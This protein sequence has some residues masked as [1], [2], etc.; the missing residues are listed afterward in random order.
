MP[1]AEER[2]QWLSKL[3]PFVDQLVENKQSDADSFIYQAYLASLERDRD[4]MI[5]AL[6]KAFELGFRGRWWLEI[7]PI[8]QH[9]KNDPQFMELMLEWKQE[10]TRMR[11]L[12]EAGS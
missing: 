12:L 3:H 10:A 11:E 1:E 9:W 7:D 2:E 8:F 6:R 4:T 5:T